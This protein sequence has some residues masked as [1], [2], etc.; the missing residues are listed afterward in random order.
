[1]K[2]A[3][4]GSSETRCR[5]VAVSQQGININKSLVLI[6]Y[7]KPI[8]AKVDQVISAKSEG[9]LSHEEIMQH[10]VCL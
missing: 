5:W 1:V 10:S 2:E 9:S 8:T 3:R 6:H 7:I 4:Y